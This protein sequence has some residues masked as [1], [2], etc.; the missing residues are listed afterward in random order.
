MWEFQEHMGSCGGQLGG[1]TRTTVHCGRLGPSPNCG[2]LKIMRG[3]DVR[4]GDE[5]LRRLVIEEYE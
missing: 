4:T 5:K 2:S 3:R 1:E